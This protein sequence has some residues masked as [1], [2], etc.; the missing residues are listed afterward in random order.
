VRAKGKEDLKGEGKG[1]G[2]GEDLE[3]FLERY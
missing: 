1:V 3:G 2:K